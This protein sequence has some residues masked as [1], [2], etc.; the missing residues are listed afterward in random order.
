M[1][2]TLKTPLYLLA[3][4]IL[5]VNL[6]HAVGKYSTRSLT[7][8]IDNIPDQRRQLDA[9]DI[10]KIVY[11]LDKIDTKLSNIIHVMNVRQEVSACPRV[12][13]GADLSI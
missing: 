11:N 12:R 3:T 2:E 10:F 5:L 9:L 8:N 1:V 7:S 6:R 13:D 4:F